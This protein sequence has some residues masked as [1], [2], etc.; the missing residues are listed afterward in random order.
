M[1]LDV[2]WEVF[3]NSDWSLHFVQSDEENNRRALFPRVRGAATVLPPHPRS[4]A[5]SVSVLAHARRRAAAGDVR[6]ARDAR[7]VVARVARPGVWS[8]DARARGVASTSLRVLRAWSS[9]RVLRAESHPG[10]RRQ[11]PAPEEHPGDPRRAPR[12]H[13]GAPPRPRRGRP[14]RLRLGRRSRHRGRPPRPARAPPTRPAPVR[15]ARARTPRRRRRRRRGGPG[16]DP[17]RALPTPD[18][19]PAGAKGVQVQRRFPHPRRARLRV[20]PSRREGFRTL[21][22][23]QR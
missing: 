21:S 7:G 23:T 14:G 1:R 6:T 16:R 19:P 15:R 5:P 3:H 4:R 17:G 20:D 2:H 9:L 11:G 22:E 8:T 18:A 10:R 12:V 13:R